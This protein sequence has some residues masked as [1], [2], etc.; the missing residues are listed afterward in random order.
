MRRRCANLPR[1]SSVHRSGR[2][3]GPHG[4]RRIS[5]A[6]PLRNHHDRSKT[7]LRL[8]AHRSTVEAGG[9]E[10]DRLLNCTR[11][12]T[13]ESQEDYGRSRYRLRLWL[14]RSRTRH[15]YGE[16]RPDFSRHASN[17]VG[18][19]RRLVGPRPRP[20]PLGTRLGTRRRL[21]LGRPGLGLGRPGLGLG[22]RLGRRRHLCRHLSLNLLSG[23]A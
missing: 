23:G 17:I 2:A 15:G 3:L 22:G 12:C 10:V 18:A 6:E 16:C 5:V 14:H 19:R 4:E 13:C 21:G 1:R 9:H 20:R 11:G 7:L 8:R